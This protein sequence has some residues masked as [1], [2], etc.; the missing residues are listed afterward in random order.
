MEGVPT[1]AFERLKDKSVRTSRTARWVDGYDM[2]RH[3]DSPEWRQ[4]AKGGG[5]AYA[6][7]RCLRDYAFFVIYAV[8]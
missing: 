2:G 4:D 1:A 7:G 6:L 8:F 5:V 3:G